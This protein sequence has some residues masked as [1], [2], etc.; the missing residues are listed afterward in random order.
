MTEC[1][2]LNQME[3]APNEAEQQAYYMPHNES[4]ELVLMYIVKVQ[5]TPFQ[6]ITF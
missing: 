3:I 1:I 2:H 4:Y 6:M 5:T